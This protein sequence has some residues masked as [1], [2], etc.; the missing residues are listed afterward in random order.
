M[1]MINY[2]FIKKIFKFYGCRCLAEYVDIRH[3]CG[4]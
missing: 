3:N 1:G 4:N 2:E